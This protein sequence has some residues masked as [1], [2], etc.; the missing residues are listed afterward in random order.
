MTPSSCSTPGPTPTSVAFAESSLYSSPRN[1]MPFADATTCAGE[2]SKSRTVSTD[3]V[4]GRLVH[5]ADGGVT[6]S[7]SPMASRTRDVVTCARR[8][9]SGA[10]S[11]KTTALLSPVP[12]PNVS[13]AAKPSPAAPT[14]PRHVPSPPIDTRIAWRLPYTNGSDVVTL[15]L[16][17]IKSSATRAHSSSI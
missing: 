14:A 10:F 5:A 16:Y 3:S 8:C 17:G 13:N 2:L 7:V 9:M 11:P 12:A 15:T 1:T 6:G 4:R